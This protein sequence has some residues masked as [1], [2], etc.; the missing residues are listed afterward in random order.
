[1]ALA[2]EPVVMGNSKRSGLFWFVIS[3]LFTAATKKSEG[4]SDIA[5]YQQR[6][7]IIV[8]RLW[9]LPDLSMHSLSD[10]ENSP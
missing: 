2:E 1:M 5:I 3:P 10:S 9:A 7:E 6:P 4:G 8:D